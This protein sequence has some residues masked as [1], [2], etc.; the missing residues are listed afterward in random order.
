MSGTEGQVT[1]TP[2]AELARFYRTRALDMAV[3][4]ASAVARSGSPVNTT[5]VVTTARTFEAYLS[6]NE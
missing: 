4:F 3:T 2:D 5:E 1:P 6:D